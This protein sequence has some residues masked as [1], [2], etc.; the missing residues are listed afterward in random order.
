MNSVVSN[1]KILGGKPVI[2]GTR[3]PVSLI[4][5]LL[6]RDY[7]FEAVIEAYPSLKK[8]DIRAAMNYAAA[9]AN[10]QERIYA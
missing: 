1:P 9:L 2:R 6:A 5:N 10:F 4:L 7:N 3:I 8:S